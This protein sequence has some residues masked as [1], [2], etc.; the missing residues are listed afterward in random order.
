[1]M[2]PQTIPITSTITTL[3]FLKFIESGA[4]ELV[5]KFSGKAV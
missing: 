2:G 5:K 3:A 4:G 1:M